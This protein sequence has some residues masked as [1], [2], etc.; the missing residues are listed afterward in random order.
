M[1][2]AM[3]GTQTIP[4]SKFTDHERKVAMVLTCLVMMFGMLN[5]L[6]DLIRS[7]LRNSSFYF[8]ES[9]MFSTFWWL[10]APL[11]WAQYILANRMPKQVKFPIL[12]ILPVA[13]HL[14]A[15]PALIWLI[16][17]SFYYH[18]YLFRQTLSYTLSEY[19]FLLLLFYTI[20]YLVL[21]RTYRNS[22]GANNEEQ[23]HLD[24]STGRFINSVLVS[25]GYKKRAVE[26][27]GILYISA[28]TPYISVHLAEK[29]Y[30]LN[31]SL[32]SVSAKL[33]PKVFV[34]VHKSAIVNVRSVT[35][36]VSRN[37]GDYDLTLDNGVQLRVSRNFA[38]RFKEQ[39]NLF[40]RLTTK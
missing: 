31:E 25:D 22:N 38:A 13:I 18:T 11:L 28:S 24:G 32:K 16:S 34:R 1:L 20:P 19:V 9:F 37:N 40:H 36:Y 4:T 30:L 17:S 21:N 14:L 3:A 6:Q 29:H 23:R 39:F 10:F 15:Y 33:D 5:V 27:S 2:N 26:V 12:F 7:N 35:N 8:S